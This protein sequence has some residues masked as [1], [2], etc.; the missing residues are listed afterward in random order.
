MKLTVQ[1]E[2]GEMRETIAKSSDSMASVPPVPRPQFATFWVHNSSPGRSQLRNYVDDFKVSS[3]AA[4]IDSRDL[5][6][7][8]TPLRPSFAHDRFGFRVSGSAMFVQCEAV[9]FCPVLSCPVSTQKRYCCHQ[10]RGR[11]EEL[12]V[13]ADA[14]R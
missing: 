5:P 12:R 1:L 10:S 14:C 8:R 4:A 11:G 9:D 7:R 2:C 13:W 3:S 6:D